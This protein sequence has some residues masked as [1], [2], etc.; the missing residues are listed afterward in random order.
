MTDTLAP[1]DRYVVEVNTGSDKT[2][3]LKHRLRDAHS[4]PSPRTN[5]R[6][7]V[8]DNI[9]TD[10][11][12][13]QKFTVMFSALKV[14]ALK[15]GAEELTFDEWVRIEELVAQ[16]EPMAAVD[17]REAYKNM[18]AELSVAKYGD[19]TWTKEI[20]NVLD[21]Y[22][23]DPRVMILTNGRV[24]MGMEMVGE[25]IAHFDMAKLTGGMPAP[26]EEPQVTKPVATVEDMVIETQI[27]PAPATAPVAVPEPAQ[28]PSAVAVMS[29]PHATATPP[30]VPA[31]V[32]SVPIEQAGYVGGSSETP[33][34]EVARMEQAPTVGDDLARH[35]AEVLAHHM[36]LMMGEIMGTITTNMTEIMTVIVDVAVREAIA[37]Q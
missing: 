10:E 19:H 16:F 33:A 11:D 4:A 17:Q 35:Q 26:V 18:V 14:P 22:N 24:A 6:Q 20:C 15:E 28:E 30:S 7:R 1:E 37:K 3:I 9:S 25:L 12:K 36:S 29:E 5:L 31:P 8:I 21:A 23:I 32:P 2:P 13:M 27:A 34:E